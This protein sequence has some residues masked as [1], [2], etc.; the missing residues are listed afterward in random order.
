MLEQRIQ[1]Q[2]FDA[3][4]LKYRSAESLARPIAEASQAIVGVLTAGGKVLVCGVGSG[5]A[6]ASLCA[7]QLIGRF[8][9][10][11]PGLAVIALG[12]DAVLSSQL[13]IAGD[14]AAILARQ[15]ATLGSPGDLLLLLDVEGQH[16]ASLAA[17]QAAH[18]NDMAVIA[19]LGAGGGALRAALGETDAA[20]SVLHERAARVLE[21]QLLILHCL[22]DTID[23]QLLGEQDP[24]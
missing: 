16:E 2:F 13:S 14:A 11:R 7:G 5:V 19:L 18:A 15:V 8:E 20:I 4:D 21:M 23:L 22:C 10:E 17:V 3:A 9:R 6:L 1:Q 12:A 24:S